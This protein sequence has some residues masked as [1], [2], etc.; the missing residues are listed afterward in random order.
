MMRSSLIVLV[1]TH[2]LYSEECC[3]G[4]DCHPVPCEQIV[5][6]KDGW[7]W[8]GVDFFR[9]MQQV[10]PDGRCHVCAGAEAF[11]GRCIYLPAS[12]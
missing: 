11:I 8:H 2:W 6:T 1:L 12:V 5:T 7:R 10:S 4:E 3:A 9:G